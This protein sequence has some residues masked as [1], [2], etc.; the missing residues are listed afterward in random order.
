MQRTRPKR[1]R[2]LPRPILYTAVR[3]SE[4]CCASPLPEGFIQLPCSRCGRLVLAHQSLLWPARRL[5]ERTGRGLV[6]VCQNHLT[7]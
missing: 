7:T 5:A 3:A 2:Q 6:V 4:V 1:R